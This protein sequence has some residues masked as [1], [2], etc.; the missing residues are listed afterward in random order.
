MIYSVIS[1]RQGDQRKHKG[2]RKMDSLWTPRNI[3]SLDGSC[4]EAID[5]SISENIFSYLKMFGMQCKKNITVEENKKRR[6][7][8]NFKNMYTNIYTYIIC[9][10]NDSKQKWF[11]KLN[12]AAWPCCCVVLP[13]S[14]FP[15]LILCP[16]QCKWNINLVWSFSWKLLLHFE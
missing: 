14:G 10:N 8:A 2:K 16:R 7:I 15:Y 12:T 1:D 6:N 9:D 4:Y 11:N 3:I 5:P 13:T